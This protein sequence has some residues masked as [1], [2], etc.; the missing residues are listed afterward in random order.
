M[1]INNRIEI[2]EVGPRDGFQSIKEF[3]STEEKK[4]IIEGIIES[5]VKKIQL[6]SFVS[7]K[8]IPQ[9]QDAEE[10]AKYFLNKYPELEFSA[11]VPNY[12][13]VYL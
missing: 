1:E 10:I 4:K 8:H 3:I 7:P 5:G 2:I 13:G 9:M 11:L 6:T 12:R